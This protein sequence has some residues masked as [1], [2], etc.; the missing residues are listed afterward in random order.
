M[1]GRVEPQN[2]C[3]RRRVHNHRKMGSGRPPPVAAQRTSRRRPKKPQEAVGSFCLAEVVSPV[4]CAEISRAQCAANGKISILVASVVPAAR[5]I[6]GFCSSFNVMRTTIRRG[7]TLTCGQPWGRSD[8]G[9]TS[10][11]E[12]GTMLETGALRRT[13]P[14]VGVR[15]PIAPVPPILVVQLLKAHNCRADH[16]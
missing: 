3:R 5:Q 12:F 2:R 6:W 10:L 15:R 7:M 11:R 9:S 14:H 8:T 4:P 1:L 13:M 16:G